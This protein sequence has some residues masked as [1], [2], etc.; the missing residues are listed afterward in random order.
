M[1]SALNTR[2]EGASAVHGLLESVV[3]YAGM[4]PPA[5][6]PLSE[7]LRQYA[8]ARSGAHGWLLG[9]FLVPLARLADLE[10]SL[11]SMPATD[12]G[13]RWPLGAIAARAAV[14]QLDAIA[15]F[16]QRWT[17]VA[18]VGAVEIA[19]VPP[20]EIGAIARRLEGLEV[21]F[22]V[23]AGAAVDTYLEPVAAARAGAKIRTGGVTPDA[24]P[25][26]DAL[27]SFV[28]ACSGIRV[29]FKATAGLHHALRGRYPLTPEDDTSVAMHGFLNLSVAA[30][31][32]HAAQASR[33]EARAALDA[34]SAESFGFSDDALH[35]ADRTIGGTELVETRRCLFRAF[36][37]CSFA[38]PVADL[39]AGGIL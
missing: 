39:E 7:A 34:S 19:P 20:S 5:N 13:A 32:V 35:W 2:A 9:R 24:F 17:G 12:V 6:L 29:P 26:T 15:A 23:P 31:L 21:F 36:G 3:D 38:E 37:S 33:R 16:N 8:S 1:G 28:V 27:A 22:E 4:F 11:R 18:S 25:D 30:A 14:G 10:D